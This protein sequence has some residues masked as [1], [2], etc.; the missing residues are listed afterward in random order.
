M[1]INERYRVDREI[2][3]GG[4]GTV[5]VGTD[6]YTNRKVAI[7]KA[8]NPRSILALQHEWNVY[9]SLRTGTTDKENNEKE[10][11]PGFCNTLFFGSC[12]GSKVL[13]MQNVGRS[14]QNLKNLH[15]KLS[16]RTVFGIGFQALTRLEELHNRGL[17]HLDVKPDNLMFAPRGDRDEK[18]LIYLIDFGVAR[19][20]R[21]ATTG[22][23][24]R[25]TTGYPFVGT[26]EFSSVNILS[27]IRPSRRDD[28]ISLG[29]TMVYLAKGKLPWL[30]LRGGSHQKLRLK[31]AKRKTWCDKF[32]TCLGLPKVFMM[33]FSYV[34]NLA[35]EDDPDYDMLRGLMKQGSTSTE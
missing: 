15:G 23:H 8:S 9:R 1:L 12:E 29:Y 2:G 5:Y 6:K 11:L 13:V 14:L 27:G 20:Y 33:Y 18:S 30:K 4:Y 31:V 21:H 16:L 28:L 26:C 22:E 10:T 32:W 19:Y 35:Y 24:V 34:S 25:Q 3:R 17:L 7:K